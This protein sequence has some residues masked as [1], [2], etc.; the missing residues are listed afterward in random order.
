M[1]RWAPMQQRE[2][3]PPGLGAVPRATHLVQQ[4][5]VLRCRDKLNRNPYNLRHLLNQT[6]IPAGPPVALHWLWLW[7]A[8]TAAWA[9]T[10]SQEPVWAGVPDANGY[11]FDCPVA[12]PH[13]TGLISGSLRQM[14]ASSALPE[15]PQ[16]GAPPAAQAGTAP[17]E[18]PG[19]VAEPPQAPLDV[20]AAAPAPGSLSAAGPPRD[21]G[22]PLGLSPGGPLFAPLRDATT[23][24][25][26]IRRQPDPPSAGGGLSPGQAPFLPHLPLHCPQ[27]VPIGAVPAPAAPSRPP[28]L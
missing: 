13:L 6:V 21:L 26:S 15:P 7:V 23:I 27:A 24:A 20:R 12:P 9:A 10:S 19:A 2:G 3:L 11:P 4:C 18:L 17:P 1:T 14:K 28:P 8:L 22:P 16:P 5:A 25:D